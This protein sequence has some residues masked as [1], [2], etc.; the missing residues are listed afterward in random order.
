MADVGAVERDD[1][2]PAAGERGA[3]AGQTV[4][5][6]YEVEP[7]PPQQRSQPPR[8]RQVL[9]LAER[10]A[11]Q[12]DVDAVPA[13]LLDLVEDPAAALWRL[14]VGLEIRDDEDPHRG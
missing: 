14:P 12:L 3:P 10:E 6:V 1:Q 9:A 4:V 11:E 5:G 13:D 8:R 7:L 2:R